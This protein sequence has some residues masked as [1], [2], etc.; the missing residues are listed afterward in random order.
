VCNDETVAIGDKARAIPSG[1]LE[2]R[3]GTLH[4]GSNVELH[5]TEQIG[6]RIG[7]CRSTEGENLLYEGDDIGT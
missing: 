5:S 2:R 6:R 1:R 4:L 3:E 7:I